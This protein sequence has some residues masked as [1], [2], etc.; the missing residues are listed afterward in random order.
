MIHGICLTES[1][2]EGTDLRGFFPFMLT[3]NFTS[4]LH[5]GLWITF[6]CLTSS[7]A[8]IR[9]QN[10]E[11]VCCE[12]RKNRKFGKES[13]FSEH[14]SLSDCWLRDFPN[15]LIRTMREINQILFPVQ[16]KFRNKFSTTFLRLRRAMPLMRGKIYLT[17]CCLLHPTVAHRRHTSPGFRLF[18]LNWI[19]K[20]FWS[21]CLPRENI[22][23][24]DLSAKSDFFICYTS[25]FSIRL[26]N[27]LSTA[28]LEASTLCWLKVPAVSWLNFCEETQKPKQNEA[29][30]WKL[31]L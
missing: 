13:Q 11:Y 18:C 22:C 25:T 28:T 9:V 19:G 7:R 1:W 26:V 2:T 12:I 3:W 5:I 30:G 17:V 31:G 23:S 20:R 16:I 24:P 8:A 10:I 15:S 27:P 21:K 14:Q 4:W 29:K 6:S